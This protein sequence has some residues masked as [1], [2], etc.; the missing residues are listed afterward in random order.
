LPSSWQCAGTGA[1]ATVSVPAAIA[2]AAVTVVFA[3]EIRV[4]RSVH[5]ASVAPV[6]ALSCGS[7]SSSSQAASIVSK[8]APRAAGTRGRVMGLSP[9]V[10]GKRRV[11]RLVKFNNYR[12]ELFLVDFPYVEWPPSL[13]K[14]ADKSRVNPSP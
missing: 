1:P 13:G 4:A 6:A 10:V 11:R 2:F 3:N 8:T 5:D 14:F 12:E 7:E 9:V